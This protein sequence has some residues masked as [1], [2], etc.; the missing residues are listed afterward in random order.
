MKTETKLFWYV[1]AGKILILALF[2]IVFGSDRLIWSDSTTYIK[3][4][5]NIFAGRGVSD[6][7]LDSP[8]AIPGTTRTLFYPL[9]LG[10]FEKFVPYG[11]VAVSLLQAFAAAGIAVLVYHIG[12]TFLDHRYAIAAAIA[13]SFEPLIASTHILIMPETFLILLLLLWMLFFIKHLT[14]GALKPLF[15]SII[16]LAL[17]VYVK[18][19]AYYLFIVTTIILFVRHRSFAIPAIALVLL[20]FLFSPWMIYNKARA[21]IFSMTT[22]DVGNL[23]SWELVALISTKY[24]IDSTD[25][26]PIAQMPEYQEMQKRCTSTSRALSLFV[27]EYPKELAIASLVSTAGIMTN[28]GYSVFFEKPAEEQIKPHHNYLTPAVVINRDWPAKISAAASEMRP[29]ELVAIVIGKM[30]W[31]LVLLFATAGFWYWTV[32]KR[33]LSA[34]FLLLFVLYIIAATVVSTGFG[35]GARL[36]LPIDPI[37]FIFALYGGY[38]FIHRFD[39]NHTS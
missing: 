18:P 1:L 38:H 33:S 7:P 36:R 26:A 32:N 35:V 39:C 3:I 25:W 12:L 8:D 13:A 21:G 37:L 16:F 2:L 14:D 6:S 27:R 5:R 29:I 19:I 31:L 20:F 23:C 28:D 9:I 34:L 22:D 30:F 15:I 10:F 24:R 17:A 11:F 4:G